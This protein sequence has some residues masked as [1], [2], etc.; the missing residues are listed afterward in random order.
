M[1]KNPS[2]MALLRPTRL[3]ILR[4][5]PPTRLNGPTRLSTWQVR[6]CGL[7]RRFELDRNNRAMMIFFRVCFF[8]QIFKDFVQNLCGF[9]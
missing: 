2:Y 5:L 4:N 8:T 3:L 6:V 1:R 9:Y 7:I